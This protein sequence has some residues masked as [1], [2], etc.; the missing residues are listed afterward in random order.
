MNDGYRGSKSEGAS[1]IKGRATNAG[2]VKNAAK[3]NA[4]VGATPMMI[5]YLAMKADYPDA[6]LFYR[7]GE[8]YELFFDDAKQAAA[9]LDIALTKRGKHLGEDIPMCG[10][11]VHAADTYL[12]RLIRHGFRVAVCEQV[13]DPAE[14][15]KRG[16][17]AIVKRDIVRLVTP[18]TLTEDT[19]LD[20]RES[21]YLAALSR[22]GGD[23][24]LG[25]LDMSTGEFI[26]TDVDANSLGGE[27]G[28][29]A[30]RE[31]LLSEKSAASS[32]IKAAL[33]EASITAAVVE[34][35][36]FDSDA[37]G[38][39]LGELFD[40]DEL[41]VLGQITRAELSVCHAL[42]AYLDETQKGNLPR[43]DPPRRQVPGGVMLI[44]AAS[45]RNLELLRT[46]AGDKRG[47]LL[48]AVDLT[49]TAAGGRMMARR[50]LSPLTDTEKIGA[51]Q[52][53]VA[54]F[55]GDTVLR[56]RVRKGLREM[57]DIERAIARLSVDRGGPRDLVAIRGGL[58]SARAIK[59]RVQEAA[60]A[61]DG[62]GA[63][64]AAAL[65]DMGS[66][67]GLINTLKSALAGEPPLQVRD[68]GF[69]APGFH[70]ALDEFRGLR[71]E[72]RRHIAALEGRYRTDTGINS[73]KVRHNNVLGYHIDVT[74][75]HADTLMN[76]PWSQGFI[77]RQ[78]LASSTR[79]ST[80]ELAELAARIGEAADRAL[81]LE[82]ELF[83]KLRSEL[84]SARDALTRLARA[85]ARLDVAA[86]G[87]RLA[88]RENYVC[89]KVDQSTAF[90]VIAG[91]HPVVEQA[92]RRQGNTPFVAND[93]DLGG[94]NRL[95]LLTGPNMAGK[96]T[97][98]RQNALI[99]ILAQAGLF[100][101]AEA[102]HIGI[103][104]RL[105]SRVGASDDLAQGRSTFMVEMMET[106]TI[107]NHGGRRALVILDEIGRGTATYDGL[108]IA[109]AA[110]EWLHDV[111]RC[112]TLFATHFH[113]LTALAETSEAIALRT[114]RVKE[115]KGA[116]HFLHEVAKGTADRSYGIHVAGLAGLPG[117]VI[118]RAKV[119]LEHLEAGDHGGRSRTEGLPLFSGTPQPP[120]TRAELV[121]LEEKLIEVVPDDLSPREALELIYGLK[122]LLSGA[123][124]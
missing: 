2:A 18:G 104:D 86:A 10:V 16:S 49:L 98:L 58:V 26:F 38:K 103:V 31:I 116:L 102:A 41:S 96:S 70:A 80:T 19:L 105:F 64:I 36:Y 111:N 8:F 6:L 90:D 11:P 56:E 76:E 1:P 122:R 4:V 124:Q 101:P 117:E 88:A 121:L 32:D 22:A 12:A 54:F 30:P 87:A 107:L 93:C 66:H 79:F 114:M 51:R 46:L 27:L 40:A 63:L 50:L 83:E 9:A 112:R 73:L 3:G 5:Q 67:D 48:A 25:W 95:W 42:L 33:G 39:R 71:D 53:A 123:G 37:G 45:Q 21:N 120:A 7:M 55:A 94:D 28:R 113:E 20:A 81:A 24:T 14:A 47:S 23:L 91:R 89:P 62:A 77:H 92:L 44:D 78:T 110:V 57:P 106:A 74:A 84:M 61:L 15:K 99:A 100:V 35:G 97:F 34:A 115:W 52:E 82:I 65:A 119:V 13:E 68:G 72:G 69:I 29:L 109:W 60:A 118:E 17:K 108:A 75:K 59:R 43:L 85:T